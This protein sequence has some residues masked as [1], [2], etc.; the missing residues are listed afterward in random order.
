MKD[1]NFDYGDIVVCDFDPSLG[2]EQKG[3]RPGLIV[4]GPEYNRVTNMRM[5]C[6]ITRTDKEY[7]FRV[8]LD[9]RTNTT[10]FVI[11]EQPNAMDIFERHPVKKEECPQDILHEVMIRIAGI[12]P[13]TFY[14]SE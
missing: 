6:P 10:G 9:D 1:S 8:A 11:C 2:H 7:P 5:I 13:N 4:S 14:D 3:R 12:F